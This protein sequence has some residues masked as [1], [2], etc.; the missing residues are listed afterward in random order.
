MATSQPPRQPECSEG[1][2]VEEGVA[3]SEGTTEEYAKENRTSNLILKHSMQIIVL[4][5][6]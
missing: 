5:A 3:F 2:V 4:W 1:G 6:R